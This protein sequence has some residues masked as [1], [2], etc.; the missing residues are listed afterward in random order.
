MAMLNLKYSGDRSRVKEL[1]IKVSWIVDSNKALDVI[2]WKMTHHE[3][4]EYYKSIIDKSKAI[5]KS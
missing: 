2:N 5:E 4:S 1:K 3:F